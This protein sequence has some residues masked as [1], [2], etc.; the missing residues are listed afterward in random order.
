MVG[1]G[2]IVLHRARVGSYSVVGSNAVVTPDTVVPDSSRALGVPA[3]V[4]PADA[5][6][7]LMITTGVEW[8][9]ARARRY[10]MG[11]VRIN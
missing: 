4:G 8:Y 6:D 7:A 11:L 10:R 1:N 2:S 9:V 3:R 5:A